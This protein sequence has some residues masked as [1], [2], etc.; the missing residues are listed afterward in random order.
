VLHASAGRK[1]DC[2]FETISRPAKTVN[3]SLRVRPFFEE[4]KVNGKTI[5]RP[6]I[7]RE[8]AGPGDLTQSLCSPWQNDYRECG[9]FYWAASRPDFVNVEMEDDGKVR[10]NN[11][12]QKDRTP[13]TAKVFVTDDRLDPRLITYEDLFRNWEQALRFVF[14]NQDEPE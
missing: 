11:W 7:A 10:G 6:V 8:L 4:L 2:E 13:D 14:G 1:V 5:R 12:M 9:C 3:V